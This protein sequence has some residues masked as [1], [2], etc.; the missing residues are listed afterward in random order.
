MQ[1]CCPHC[2]DRDVREFTY[3]GDANRVR[4][5]PEAPDALQRFIEYVTSG[6]IRLVRIG[7]SGITNQAAIWLVVTRDT[8]THEVLG[9][10]VRRKR[11][12]DDR[13]D[14]QAWCWSVSAS[15]GGLIDRS[16]AVS[17]H[18]DG[19]RLAGFAGD[20][21]ASA[22]LANG[23]RVVAR[24]FKYHRP[25]GIMTAGPEEPNGLVELGSGARR[26]PNTKATAIELY[27]GLVA[28][29]QNRWPSLT[30]D[31][32]SLNSLLAPFL[33]AG[34]YY[35]TFMWPSAFWERVYEPLIRRADWTRRA[36][37]EKDP[38]GYEQANAF[39]DLLV[40]GAGPAGISAALV[41][42]RAGAR[43]VLCEDDFR[44]GAGFWL[45]G[46]RSMA[47]R[48]R[49]GS[50]HHGR[51]GCDLERP[52]DASNRGLWSVRCRC[53]RRDRTRIR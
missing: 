2:G 44:F 19:N 12:S 40:I 16:T 27:D 37:C 4:P 35:K 1:I 38:D 53:L 7:S 43:V 46:M 47:R 13:F 8:R 23:N 25:R 30:F 6:Q 52:A 14:R 45:I 32:L 3:L 9:V 24:S 48:R 17:F 28:A 50:G 20:T 39:C 29:S 41:A 18:F 31:V 15:E 11:G 34:F 33:P 22:L 36:A 5:D 21:L 42:A 49:S 51:T 26:E 10:A